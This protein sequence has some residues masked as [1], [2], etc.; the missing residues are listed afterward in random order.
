M[1]THT[2]AQRR[3]MLLVELRLL[4]RT[5]AAKRVI[6]HTQREMRKLRNYRRMMAEGMMPVSE[7]LRTDPEAAP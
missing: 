7:A 4:R 1:K 5:D 3:F 6:K 2:Y